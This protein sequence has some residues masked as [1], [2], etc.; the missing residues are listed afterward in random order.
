MTKDSNSRSRIHLISSLNIKIDL[1]LYLN[2]VDSG[3]S[4]V[5]SGWLV[6]EKVESGLP[7]TTLPTV[8]MPL[9][10]MCGFFFILLKKGFLGLTPV[11]SDTTALGGR[12]GLRKAEIVKG[13]K[14][15]GKRS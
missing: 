7:T 12:W 10:R 5:G 14:R 4:V 11:C 3:G 6:H 13:K 1:K 2:S 9:K 15:A 8:R